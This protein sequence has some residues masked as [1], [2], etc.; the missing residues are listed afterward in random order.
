LLVVLPYVGVDLGWGT[1]GASGGT[2]AGTGAGGAPAAP[3]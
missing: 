1:M 2:H 3:P